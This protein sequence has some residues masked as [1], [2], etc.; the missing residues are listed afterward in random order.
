MHLHYCH[1]THGTLALDLAQY[2][3]IFSIS[4]QDHD[5]I[6]FLWGDMSQQLA[7][8]QSIAALWPLSTLQKK[9]VPTHK[10]DRDPV[11]EHDQQ[12]RDQD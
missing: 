5:F 12:R 6:F 3:A 9:I 10:I 11:R 7:M 8:T 1:F 2:F 4:D